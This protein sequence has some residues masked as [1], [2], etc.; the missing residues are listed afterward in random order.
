MGVVGCKS[1]LDYLRTSWCDV[2]REA[3]WQ[4]VLDAAQERGAL[5][6]NALYERAAE[7]SVPSVAGAMVHYCR[8]IFQ[9]MLKEWR[10][11][12]EIEAAQERMSQDIMCSMSMPWRSL[13]RRT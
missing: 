12:R 13:P 6:Q 10:K 8:A 1:L 3:A 9:E 7:F 4:R 11:Q 5:V 2:R